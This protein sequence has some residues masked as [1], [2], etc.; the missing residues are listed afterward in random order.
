MDFKR[1]RA[2]LGK[3]RI[4]SPREFPAPGKLPIPSTRKF[5]GGSPVVP[6]PSGRPAEWQA[7]QSYPFEAAGFVCQSD[8][9]F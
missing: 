7:Q 5:N 9:R 1:F 2:A 3:L 4:P 6:R 8:F